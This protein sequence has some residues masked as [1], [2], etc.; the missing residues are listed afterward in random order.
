M[1]EESNRTVNFFIGFFGSIAILASCIYLYNTNIS[2]DLSK[3]SQVTG[4]V[5]YKDIRSIKMSDSYRY[6]VQSKVFCFRLENSD[7]LFTVFRSSESYEGLNTDIRIGDTVKVYYHP[8]TGTYNMHVFQIENKNYILAD[9]RKFT[10]TA[11]TWIGLGI[12]GS[13]I[14]MIGF[15]MWYK[16]ISLV[17]LLN[18]LVE[19]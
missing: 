9:Y 17:R 4:P 2:Q 15:Y 7:Q 11:S 12:F 6:K 18:S 8:G 3:C 16:K 10:E 13:I 5:T 1:K 14:S 19:P